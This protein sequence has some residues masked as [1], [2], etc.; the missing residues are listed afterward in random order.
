MRN[1]PLCGEEKNLTQ[2]ISGVG[3]VCSDCGFKYLDAEIEVLEKVKKL[4][5]N[6]KEK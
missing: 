4:L 2:G 5:M 1:C 3:L 6:D